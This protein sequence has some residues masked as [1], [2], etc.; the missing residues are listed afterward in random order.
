MRY[1]WPL[2]EKV[3]WP[4]LANVAVV[5]AQLGALVVAEG[6]HQVPAVVLERTEALGQAEA[7]F[8]RAVL[9]MRVADRDVGIG[10]VALGDEVDDAGDGV[11]AVQGRGAVGQQF[12]AVDGRDRNRI[13]VEAG[14]EA[15]ERLAAELRQALAVQQDQGTGFAHVMDRNAR[16][17]EGAAADRCR[18]AGR[19]LH[20][21]HALHQVGHRGHARSADGLG[22]NDRDRQRALGRDPLDRGTGDL[23]AL[24]GLRR[25]L[26]LLR[27]LL[28]LCQH[29]R[30]GDD[31]A[32]GHAAGK[33][34]AQGLRQSFFFKHGCSYR[35]KMGTR[36]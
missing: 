22:G 8:A 7:A 3:R 30:G 18:F 16:E 29:R 35:M 24:H 12:D 14:G 6:Q 9:G 11:G 20:R 33:H 25:R 19:A 5:R 34:Q 36:R 23:H 2:C 26:L 13:E 32:E 27:R 4:V 28:F 1:C 15:G 10:P 17:A 31:Q 21:R